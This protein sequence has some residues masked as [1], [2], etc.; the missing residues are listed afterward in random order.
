MITSAKI[1]V[2]VTI[3]SGETRSVDVSKNIPLL[4]TPGTY[5]IKIKSCCGK[6]KMV[7]IQIK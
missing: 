6:E 2:I 4:Q 7:Q 3:P 5:F 1:K